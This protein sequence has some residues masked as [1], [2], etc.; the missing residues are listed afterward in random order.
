MQAVYGAKAQLNALIPDHS[1]DNRRL[2]HPVLRAGPLEVAD[3][4]G[5]ADD[6]LDVRSEARLPAA[7]QDQLGE[8]A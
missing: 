7:V 4:G 6:C 5:V 8:P 3:L 1:Q 2:A